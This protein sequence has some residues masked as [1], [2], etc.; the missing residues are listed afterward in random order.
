M[1]GLYQDHYFHTLL[2]NTCV[3]KE[4]EKGVK[5]MLGIYLVHFF[6]TLLKPCVFQKECE[7]NVSKIAH[8]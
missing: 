8:H 6:H 5:I 1:W 4:C 3:F 7:N 2:K